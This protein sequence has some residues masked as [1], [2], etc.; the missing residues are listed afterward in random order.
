[1]RLAFPRFPSFSPDE[2]DPP[3][4][5]ADHH[6]SLVLLTSSSALTADSNPYDALSSSD[7]LR[8]ERQL[9][10]ASEF[11]GT[12][13]CRFVMRDTGVL[14]DKCAFSLSSTSLL[15]SRC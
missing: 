11:F 8:L 5:P 3:Q 9:R 4:F 7:R 14:L 12:V 2:A 15:T 6:L 1:M 13:I 10:K